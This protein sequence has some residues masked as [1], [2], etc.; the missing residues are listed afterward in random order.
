MILVF[1][2]Q[3]EVLN[4]EDV[5]EAAGLDFDLT[6]VP[7]AVNPNCGLALSI[8]GETAEAVSLALSRAGL[9]PAASYQRQTGV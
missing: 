7:K 9:T 6:P 3:T 5:L 8:P 1:A 4:A 2:S